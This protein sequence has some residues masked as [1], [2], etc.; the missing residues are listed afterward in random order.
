MLPLLDTAL[1]VG[2]T[3]AVVPALVDIL[4]R[5]EDQPAI[6]G[7]VLGIFKSKGC[8]PWLAEAIPVLGRIGLEVYIHD[9]DKVKLVAKLVAFVRFMVSAS[10]VPFLPNFVQ[11]WE[12]WP[13]D[14][15]LAGYISDWCPLRR[16]PWTPGALCPTS[17]S[18]CA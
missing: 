13:D 14:K 8:G 17:P 3:I 9:L 2:V 18:S 15:E 16:A 5:H 11:A 4:S 7:T 1:K 10:L 12:R 6:V